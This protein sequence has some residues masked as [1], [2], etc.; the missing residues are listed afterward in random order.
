[1]PATDALR[2]RLRKVQATAPAQY[3][4]LLETGSPSLG[5]RALDESGN[6]RH[7]SYG[8]AAPGAVMGS[9]P[10]PFGGSAPLFTRV[11]NGYV[12]AFSNDLAAVFN[13]LEGTFQIAARVNAA[14]VWT[15]ANSNI[16][17]N[18]SI[19]ANNFIQITQDTANRLRLRVTGGGV[20][21][22]CDITGLSELGWMILHLTYSRTAMQVKAFYQGVQAG[23]TA[24]CPLMSGAISLAVVG[25]QST[26][27]ANEWEGGLSEYAYWNR[28]LSPAEIAGLANG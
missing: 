3:L 2:R 22:I 14:G 27:P 26:A 20:N 21:G 18:V 16:L 25:A 9:M 5:V 11:N 12:N 1:M 24:A 17:I 4:R 7:G 28:A 8:A 6:E 13:P 23:T 19:D 15:D 10:G